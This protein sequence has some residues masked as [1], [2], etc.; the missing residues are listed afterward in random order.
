[1]DYGKRIFFCLFAAVLLLSTGS[2][3]TA[4]AQT[5]PPLGT[6]QNFAVLGASTV[7]NAV[8]AGTIL[9]GNL[10]VWPGS[11]VTGF[12]PGVVIGTIHAADGTA[13]T[14]QQDALTAYNFLAGEACPGPNNLTGQDLGGMTLLP[15]VYCFSSSA[16]LTG[17]LT[18]NST[19]SPN[20]V[21]VFKIG[22]TFTTASNSAV[23]INGSSACNVFFQVGTSATLGT[24][25]KLLGSIFAETSITMTTGGS[26]TGG[27]YALN[28]A[29][30]LDTNAVTDCM[31]TLQVC[32]EAGSSSL[33]GNSFGFSIAGSPATLIS[34]QAGPPPGGSCSVALLVPAH[35]S[36][37]TETIPAN[38]TLAAVSTL[39]TPGLLISSNLGAG[40]ATV[41][42]D[43]GAQTIATFVNTVPP[44]PTTGFLEICKVA[45]ANVTQGTT[46]TFSVAGI[47]P[48]I[49]QAG[50]APGG[51]CSS[52][53]VMPAGPTLIT[54]TL[55]GYA[56]TAV[57]T[58]P[59]GLLVSSNLAAGTATVTV[60]AGLTTIVTFVNATIP[61]PNTGFLQICKVAGAGIVVGTPFA[62]SVA[63]PLTALSVPAGPA[64]GG[65]CGLALVVPAGPALITETVPAGTALTSVSTLPAGLLVVANLV[66][67]TAT[68]TVNAGGTTIVTFLNTSPTGLLKICKIAGTGVPTGGMFTFV[69]AGTGLTVPA[70]PAPGSCSQALVFPVGTAV[71]VTETVSSGTVLSAISVVPASAGSNINVSGRSV[72]ATIGAG[73]TDVYFTN[74]A[75]GVGLLKVCKVAGRGVAPL[76]MFGFVMNGA[77]FTVPAGYCVSRGTF[78][79]GTPVT[80]TENLSSTTA[81]SAISVVP[82]SA[83]GT[84]NVS[85]R[86]ATVTVAVGTTEVTFTNVAR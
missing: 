50:A 35:P 27:A 11:A 66:A 64:P 41:E 44:P 4:L 73:E 76:T 55:N 78:P 2:L 74:T 18:L 67:G 39:P 6:A 79:V 20:G 54:E 86:S 26:V 1:M 14:A 12:P 71:P 38:T 81:V 19:G 34:V 22:S 28:G 10:G 46:F 40:T 42:V 24:G 15:G 45:G 59:A 16:Q 32:K 68:V 47:P 77:G 23:V 30:T 13:A 57:S 52:P 83:A 17:T 31:G 84:V 58:L 61:P 56:L 8:S 75:G 33:A 7:T 9:T 69:V 43:P 65:S 21:F 29:V 25:T 49:V 37:I 60:N 53:L 5:A 80:I 82:A 3:K 70:G 36:I 62:F 51:S 48:V 63:A 85:S 72:T